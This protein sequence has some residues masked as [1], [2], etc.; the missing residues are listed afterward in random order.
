MIKKF[1]CHQN[2]EKTFKINK[3]Y[4]P[5]CS[6][7]TGLYIGVFSYFLFVYFVYIQYT[8]LIELLAILMITPTILDGTTQYLHI[9]TSNNKIRLTTGIIGGIGAAIL[10]KTT[11][12]I[13]IKKLNL[14]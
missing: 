7:C 2:P 8:I 1:I 6:R 11:K 10:I 3:H 13:L 14:I 9:R 5:V 12:W 4:L